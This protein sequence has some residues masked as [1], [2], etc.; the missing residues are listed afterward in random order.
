[1]LWHTIL[2]NDISQVGVG[3]EHYGS[4]MRRG[5]RWAGLVS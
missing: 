5:E 3:K 1:M 4:G 2:C